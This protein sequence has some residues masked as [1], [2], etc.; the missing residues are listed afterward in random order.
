MISIQKTEMQ[1]QFCPCCPDPKHDSS[2]E[3]HPVLMGDLKVI[4]V[5]LPFHAYISKMQI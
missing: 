4:E 5:Q 1:K 3:L 2:L